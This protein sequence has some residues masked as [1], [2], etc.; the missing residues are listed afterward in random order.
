MVFKRL[1]QL[2]KQ[3]DYGKFLVLPEII[4][5]SHKKC[6]A[7]RV[8]PDLTE[9]PL[10]FNHTDVDSLM[11]SSKYLLSAAWSVIKDDLYPSFI[12]E[13]QLIIFCNHEGYAI[14][15]MS[16]PKVLDLCSA[17][18][19]NVGSCFSEETC[20]TN[21]IALAM[22]LKKLVVIK[23]EQHYCRLFKDWCCVAA[24]VRLP[25]RGIAGYLDVSM[26]SEDELSQALVSVQL[27]VKYIEAKLQA[28]KMLA[29]VASETRIPKALNELAALSPRESQVI[30][31]IAQGHT[32]SEIAGTMEISY[33]TVKT[34]LKKIYRKLGVNK[35]SDC[36]KKVRELGLLDL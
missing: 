7:G 5:A 9:I 12:N 19:I 13:D 33:E 14:A 3:R 11:E 4:N 34:H 24:P 15:L 36:I 32:A 30:R 35:K 1:K 27:A 10:V 29:E 22:R 25:D 17:K 31:L 2:K 16:S 6:Q 26:D 21:A 23:G 18:N 20:G 28:E 8:N